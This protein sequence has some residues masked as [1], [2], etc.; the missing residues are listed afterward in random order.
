MDAGENEC[1]AICTDGTYIWTCCNTTPVKLI[2]FKISDKTHITFTLTG[3]LPEIIYMTLIDNMIY[4]FSDNATIQWARFDTNILAFQRFTPIFPHPF[5][6]G[7]IWNDKIA[8]MLSDGTDANIA[9]FKP[10]EMAFWVS[11]D[12]GSVGPAGW[13]TI[14]NNHAVWEGD[15]TDNIDWEAPITDPT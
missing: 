6:S 2:R 7:A 11:Q 3:L 5:K 8:L 1:K 15:L 9:I 12:L 13:L 10:D 4:M 14:A